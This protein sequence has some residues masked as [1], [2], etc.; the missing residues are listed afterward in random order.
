MLLICNAV[1]IFLLFY[2]LKTLNAMSV[3]FSNF[4]FDILFV[5]CTEAGTP[6]VGPTV[7]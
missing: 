3:L 6:H 2:A 5:I 4:G 7:Y 1:I